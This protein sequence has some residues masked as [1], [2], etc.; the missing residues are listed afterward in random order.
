MSH[1]PRYARRSPPALP[2][3]FTDI[4]AMFLLLKQKKIYR[5]NDGR[6]VI[7]ELPQPGKFTF[8]RKEK[9]FLHRHPEDNFYYIIDRDG[10]IYRFTDKIHKKNQANRVII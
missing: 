1:H 4:G 6:G 9:L 10:L 2:S 8:D 7:F 5:L 3:Y